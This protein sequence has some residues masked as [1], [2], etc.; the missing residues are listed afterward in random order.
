MVPVGR[1]RNNKWVPRIGTNI[2]ARTD[3][4][5]KWVFS[6]GPQGPHVLQVLLP[7]VDRGISSAVSSLLR[8]SP[9]PPS[10]LD[11]R[12]PAVV[13]KPFPRPKPICA[14][15]TM[16]GRLWCFRAEYRAPGRFRQL[17]LPYTIGRDGHAFPANMLSFGRNFVIATCR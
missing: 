4:H 6:R 7:S 2:S 9:P 1:R 3:H 8:G 14:T 17:F 11:D 5:D 15:V 12:G 16:H 10:H 13:G